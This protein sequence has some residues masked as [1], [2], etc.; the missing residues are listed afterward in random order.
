[1]IRISIGIFSEDFGVMVLNMTE[2]CTQD[3][4]IQKSI[5]AIDLHGM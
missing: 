5:A 4:K 2:W 3:A 1:M